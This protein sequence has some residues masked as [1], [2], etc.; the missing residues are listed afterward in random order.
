MSYDMGC[1]SIPHGNTKYNS[2]DAFIELENEIF[3]FVN[4]GEMC[5]Y[6][7]IYNAKTGN[8]LDFVQPDEALLEFF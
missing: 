8:L 1:V 2:E 4:E 5:V 7:T 3:N 6:L